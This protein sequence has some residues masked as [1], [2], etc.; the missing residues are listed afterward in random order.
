[1]NR[2]FIYLISMMVLFVS[3]TIIVNA[4]TVQRAS[5]L[6]HGQTVPRSDQQLANNGILLPGRLSELDEA[7]AC[8]V[9]DVTG[10]GN[11]V[12][13]VMNLTPELTFDIINSSSLATADLSAYDFIVIKGNQNAT[14]NQNVLNSMEILDEYVNGGGWLEFHMGTNTHDPHMMLWDGTTY[15]ED[16]YDNDNWMADGADGHPILEGVSEPYEGTY[17]NHGYLLALPESAQILVETTAGNPTLA[18]Y[19]YGAGSVVVTTMTM[20]Y[21]WANYPD[22]SGLILLNCM[23]YMTEFGGV[24]PSELIVDPLIL[25]FGSI[26]EG[27]TAVLQLEMSASEDLPVIIDSYTFEFPTG[28]SMDMNLPFTIQPYTE[29]DVD[30]TFAPTAAADWSSDLW[31]HNDGLLEIVTVHIIAEAEAV[32]TSQ[33]VVSPLELDFGSIFEGETVVLPLQ[34]SVTGDDPITIDGY[35]F[36]FP[37]GF[38]IDLIVPYTLQPTDVID[39]DVT[40][41]PPAAADWSSDLW[42][43]S[44]ATNPIVTVSLIADATVNS[45]AE[46]NNLL[47]MTL[48]IAGVYPN[49]FNASTVIE[50]QAPVGRIINAVIYD[51]RGREVLRY[52]LYRQGGNS[53]QLAFEADNLPSGLYFCHVTDGVTSVSQKLVLLK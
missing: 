22:E 20:E 35:T 5:S 1:M 45:V 53:T 49:P 11:S 7:S 41:A 34:M 17:A 18:E 25:D 30:V 24:R 50:I 26:E 36:Q 6:D 52:E 37:T 51:L 47:P 32:N 12:E 38:E 16:D 29:V 46:G 3:I 31:I 44:N 42:I 8:L 2:S 13:A 9:R 23:S 4:G 33:L 10:W 19:E 21:L 28:F 39:V 43:N 14:F 27:Q 48:E 15:S 40:F